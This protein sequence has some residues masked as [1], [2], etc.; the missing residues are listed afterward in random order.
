MTNHFKEEKGRGLF[1]TVYKGTILN[2]QKLVAVK[3]LGKAL[4]E[5]EKSF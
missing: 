5:G 1:G 3:R 2:G 4:S